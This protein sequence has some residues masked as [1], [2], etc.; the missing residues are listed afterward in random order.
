MDATKKVIAADVSRSIGKERRDNNSCLRLFFD[1]D[2][3]VERAFRSNTRKDSS[4]MNF[5]TRLTV[6][7]RR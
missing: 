5:S 7:P 1:D 6:N 3:K 4:S 2:K